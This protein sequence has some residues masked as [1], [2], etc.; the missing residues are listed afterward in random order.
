MVYRDEAHLKFSP[1]YDPYLF[2]PVEHTR[3]YDY[4]LVHGL[5]NE[6]QRELA[7][8]AKIKLPNYRT[9]TLVSTPHFEVERIARVDRWRLYQVKRIKP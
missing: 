8:K 2:D 4:F 5:P 9:K 6:E 3:G 1:W 7:K